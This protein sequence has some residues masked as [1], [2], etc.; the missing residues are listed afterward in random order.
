M[1]SDSG[2]AMGTGEVTSGKTEAHSVQSLDPPCTRKGDRREAV[3]ARN[4][5]TESRLRNARVGRARPACFA[6]IINFYFIISCNMFLFFV[7]SRNAPRRR[8]VPTPGRPP[9]PDT[10]PIFE[11]PYSERRFP[12]TGKQM[13]E[14]RVT[15]R[16]VIALKTA[17]LCLGAKP[18][19]RDY[20]VLNTDI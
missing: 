8:Q 16:A 12:P 1:P 19:V 5:L 4:A 2:R 14:R 20:P 11:E 13:P 18:V 17:Q 9:D 10:R 6:T 7:F 15:Q 3:N